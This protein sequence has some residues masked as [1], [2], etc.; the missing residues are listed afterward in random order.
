MA[1]PLALLLPELPVDDCVLLLP[2]ELWLC[3]F[4][5]LPIEPRSARELS[6]VPLSLSPVSNPRRACA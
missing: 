3:P 2:D 4:W 5:L 6:A 1:C